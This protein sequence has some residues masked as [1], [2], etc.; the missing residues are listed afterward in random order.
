MI[1]ADRWRPLVRA[2]LK[3]RKF[4]PF[5][6]E[7]R[8]CSWEDVSKKSG[9]SSKILETKVRLDEL[10]DLRSLDAKDGSIALGK[11]EQLMAEMDG[12]MQQRRG[13]LRTRQIQD[14]K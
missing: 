3:F 4:E 1:E 11:P 2:V 6:T 14:N 5:E 12:F 13:R 9:D 8:T 10:E 7:R